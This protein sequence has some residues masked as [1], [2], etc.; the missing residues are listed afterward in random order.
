M[1]NYHDIR[2]LHLEISTRCNAACPDCPRNLRGVDVID[3]FPVTDMSLSEFKQIFPREFLNQIT[4]FLINGNHGDF[5][6]ARDGLQIVEYVRANSACTIDI[7]TNASGKP[8]IWAPL[9]E[10]GVSVIFRL[11]GLADTHH[12][13]RQNTDFHLIIDNAKKFIAAC[14][15]NASSRAVWCMIPFDH[16]RHQIESAEQMSRDL[17]FHKFEICDAGRDT[18]PVFDSKRNFS[19]IIGKWTGSKDFTDI[20]NQYEFYTSQPEIELAKLPTTAKQIFCSAKTYQEIYVTAN[21]E[22]YPCCFLG[23]YPHHSSKG[24]PLNHQ[25]REIVRNNN[26]LEHGLP[27]ALAW[28]AE[29]ERSWAKESIQAGRLHACDHICGVKS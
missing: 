26:A 23:F 27:A 8:K 20:Y 22:V 25:L 19:H 7:S 13:Y 24:R 4:K 28:I 9:A 10:L 16:N 21:G 6:T 3:T 17:G 12:L 18:M 14:K 5:I 29:V 2:T 11:D 15:N 1:I